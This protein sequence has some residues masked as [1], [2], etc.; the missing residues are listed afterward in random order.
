MLIVCVAKENRIKK[1]GV[2]SERG[3]YCLP[4][5]GALVWTVYKIRKIST[6]GFYVGGCDFVSR[7]VFKKQV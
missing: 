6:V 2:P 4:V 5:S 1:S 7:H 3:A